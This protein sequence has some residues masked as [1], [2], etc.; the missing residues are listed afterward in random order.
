[1]VWAGCFQKCKTTMDGPR[2]ATLTMSQAIGELTLA[3]RATAATA[4]IHA[5]ARLRFL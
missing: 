2:A 4:T 1:M 3:T 5:P